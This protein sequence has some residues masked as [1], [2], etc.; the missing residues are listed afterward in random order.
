MNC[1]TL[2]PGSQNVQSRT[3]DGNVDNEHVA[4]IYTTLDI[5][6]TTT[7]TDDRPYNPQNT[8]TWQ[9]V[10]RRYDHPTPSQDAGN[11]VRSV[12]SS[13][14]VVDDRTLIEARHERE[15]QSKNGRFVGFGASGAPEVL[16]KNAGR[17]EPIPWDSGAAIEPKADIGTSPRPTAM[18]SSVTDDTEGSSKE[19]EG[20]T[21]SGSWKRWTPLQSEDAAPKERSTA[22][23]RLNWWD[24]FPET[25]S[26]KD[27]VPETGSAP[28]RGLSWWDPS[29]G[30]TSA[31]DAAP[32]TGST[33]LH[34]TGLAEETIDQDDRQARRDERRAKKFAL[35]DV[36]SV[37]THDQVPEG[38]FRRR[39]HAR[40]TYDED[41]EDH[42]LRAERKRQR[43]HEK[44]SQRAVAAPVPIYLPEFISV[45]NLATALKVKLEEFL[46]TMNSMGFEGLSND[47][48]LDGETAGLIAV[49]YNFDPIIDRS[50]SQDLQARPPPEDKSLLPQR[51]PVVT[52][53]GHVDHGKTTLLDWLRKSSV[54]ASEHGGI[55]Q[56][57]G[58]FSVPM[59]S[60]KVIT[61]LDTP[62]HA[63]FL[64]MRQRGANVTDVVILVVAADDSVK[65]QTIEAIKHAKAA[66]V[67]IIV[68]VNKIDKEDANAE[69]V[70]QDLARHGVEV[71]DYGGDTQVVCVS[72]K[73]GQGMEEL[74]EAVVALADI[75]DMRAET[76]GP[77]EGWVLEATTKKAG[78]VATVLVRRGT[79]RLGNV[80]VAGSTWARIRSLRNEAG[81][82]VESAGPGTPVEIAGW[83]EQ[84]IA[85]DEVIE[86]TDEQKA[87][88]VVELR[89]ERNDRSKMAADMEAV[90]DSRRSEQ[91][92]REREKQIAD[93]E[94]VDGP[95]QQS[96]IK[97]VFFIVKGDVSGSVEA[98]LNSVS[99]LGNEEV[100]AHILRSGVGPVTEF[101]VEHSAVAKG[102]IISFNTPIE[103]NISRAAEAAGVSIL[104]QNIIYRLVDD[105]KARLSEQLT[106]LKTQ[107][108]VGEADIAQVFE[109]NSKGKTLIPIAGCKIRNGIVHRNAKVKVLRDK[110]VIYDGKNISHY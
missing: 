70:K 45:S 80:I 91:E 23:P 56:H 49:E 1:T 38:R 74:E 81:A 42:S 13:P 85:G 4:K 105:V 97:E 27:A 20:T 51:P 31:T 93:G 18:D 101:D 7:R 11:V 82:Q 71:E 83:R 68:A 109:I 92:G 53:M 104:D 66:T 90:N 84:P 99:A 34:D 3:E 108:V 10:K 29:V 52:I 48:V 40:S 30:S 26:A 107:R 32:K 98:V 14:A 57:I 79:M 110:E 103:A 59:P 88:S 16:R 8:S 39:R 86:A 65:P 47:H 69:R 50:E 96:G 72:G 61:F 73:T 78:R 44:I 28:S 21:V 55:T 15:K 36:A 106:P 67:P 77:A 2:K 6:Q 33:I 25:T 9:H 54:A 46:Y 60:G 75:L 5:S 41:E 24:Q 43:K 76:D 17:V 35:D 95:E 100:R 94:R 63:A 12:L 102:H 19:N 89:L 58:A 37:K 62:G 22:S 64:S 87:K